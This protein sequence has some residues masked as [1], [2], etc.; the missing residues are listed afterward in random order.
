MWEDFKEAELQKVNY[1][2]RFLQTSAQ[3]TILRLFEL[4]IND[5]CYVQILRARK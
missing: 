1:C 5:G 4:L 2:T 3:G